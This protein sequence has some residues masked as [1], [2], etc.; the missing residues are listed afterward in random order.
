MDTQTPAADTTQRPSTTDNGTNSITRCG[1]I[2]TSW[3][4]FIAIMQ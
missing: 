3:N 1:P 2:E 4:L